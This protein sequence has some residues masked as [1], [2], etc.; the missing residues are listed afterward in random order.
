MRL[1]RL[2][3]GS[4][5]PPTWKTK[6]CTRPWGCRSSGHGRTKGSSESVTVH[7]ASGVYHLAWDVAPLLTTAHPCKS[8]FRP[9]SPAW[10]IEILSAPTPQ[11]QMQRPK[12]K[13]CHEGIYLRLFI[14]ST[15]PLS[16]TDAGWCCR[17]AKEVPFWE[18][19]DVRAR[20]P[21]IR[22]PTKRW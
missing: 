20:A 14:Q 8:L 13:I 2:V 1:G 22:H 6:T 4:V 9:R 11:L 17:D 7:R 19:P 21:E 10:Q 18:A 16:G 12:L 15:P 5:R 3:R